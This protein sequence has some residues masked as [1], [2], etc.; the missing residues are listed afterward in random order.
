MILVSAYHDAELIERAEDH[1]LAYLVKPIKQADLE[2]AIAIATR[3][4]EQFQALRQA[5]PST[6]A[7]RWR[8]A[9]IIE[10]AKGMLMK[11]AGLDEQRGLPPPAKTGQRKEPQAGRGGG[12]D[13]DRRGSLSAGRAAPGQGPPRPTAPDRLRRPPACPQ[14]CDVDSA[15]ARGPHEGGCGM[16]SLA[17]AEVT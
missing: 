6:S 11:R 7:R 17:A 1:I 10:R 16:A 13:P 5:R 15:A 8:I 12:H 14:P 4:F 2:P 9:K 3:R